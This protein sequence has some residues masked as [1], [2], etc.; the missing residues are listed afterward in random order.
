MDLQ[1]LSIFAVDRAICHLQEFP[2]QDCRICSIDTLTVHFRNQVLFQGIIDSPLP[3]IHLHLMD[4]L[5]QFR[6]IQ[7]VLCFHG[8]GDISDAPVD[9][10]LCSLP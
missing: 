3:W 4:C 9:L 8:Y 7:E 2:G 5:H 1:D 10:L 6:H